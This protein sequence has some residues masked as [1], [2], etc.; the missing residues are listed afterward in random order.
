[1]KLLQRSVRILTPTTIRQF[2]R[3]NGLPA[4]RSEIQ[5]ILLEFCLL[6]AI[7]SPLEHEE[8]KNL[9]DDLH[10]IQ[11]WPTVSGNLACSDH[12]DLMLPRDDAE[13][14][15]FSKSRATT[16]LD[17]S[18]MSPSVRKLLLNDIGN[19]AVVMRYRGLGDLA[20]DWPA[21]YLMMPRPEDSRGWGKRAFEL[22]SGLQDMWAWMAQRFQE[23]ER[24]DLERSRDLW[25]V[26]MNDFRIRQFAPKALDIPLLI[27][28]KQD[29]LFNI[30]VAITK[31]DSLEMP[32][33]LDTD[34]LSRKQKIF[35][36]TKSL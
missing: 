32:P 33:L 25:L 5:I 13:M 4:L 29:P 2:F 19:L 24:M 36:A 27:I 21:M 11:I 22:D 17:I 14:Q 18:M 1:M 31:Q 16:T 7:K 10:G 8:R 34:I 28:E 9:Y 6:D 35:C 3:R 30:L 20:T 15:L 12:A 23:G 26:P